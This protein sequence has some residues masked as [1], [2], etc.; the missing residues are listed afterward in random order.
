MR[1]SWQQTRAAL[2][3]DWRAGASEIRDLLRSRDLHLALWL[4][5]PALI[6]GAALR[7]HF[8]LE[9]PYGFFLSDTRDFIDAARNFLK[10]PLGVFGGDS[11]T[12]LAPVLYSVPVALGAP[13][14]RVVPWGQHAIGLAM[15]VLA[16]LLCAAWLRRW[17]LWIVPVTLL[18]AAHPTVLWYEH[19]AL[20][21]SMFVALAVATAAAVALFLRWPSSA[22][23]SVLMA[24]VFLAAG[25]RQEGF[26][27]ALA[28]AVAAT[29]AFR[30]DAR[31]MAA[32][33]LACAAFIALTTRASRTTQGGQMLLTSLIHLAPD[34]LFLTPDYSARAVALRERFGP[35]WPMYPA[36]H[37]KSRDIIVDDMA[38]FLRD[39][40]GL[41]E[42]DQRLTNNA[43]CKWVALEIAVR[44]WWALPRI[45]YNKWRATHLEPPS[46]P[47]GGEWPAQ[48]ALKK[49]FGEED[50]K[51]RKYLRRLFGR[52]Y[53]AA[54]AFER[55]LREVYYR[56]GRQVLLRAWQ[57]WF[58]PRSLWPH[59]PANVPLEGPGE[60]KQQMPRLPWLYP[61]G[62][63]GLLCAALAAD[64]PRRASILTWL[65]MLLVVAFV[66]GL[67][68]SLR[69]RYRLTFEP[70]WYIG[71]AGLC[72]AGLALALAAW[73]N[74]RA[75]GRARGQGG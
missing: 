65:S 2:A 13:L 40:R 8:C 48:Y 54:D 32:Y 12:F 69:S 63:A 35:Q 15:I 68:G 18:A 11:R 33:L 70:Y 22:T 53:D 59:D 21:E 37:N 39:G 6:L 52:S 66:V 19:M 60:I 51:E 72:D 25:A 31:R 64:R 14:L 47:F 71:L 30:R 50:S 55:D 56:D 9:A 45:A 43:A 49:S 34:R 4:C 42:T 58:I 5:V 41:S 16:G 36:K 28:P 23:F 67:V 3:A 73:R 17:R 1:I 57:E 62:L 74:L 10:G 29:V 20:P 26:L 44:R 38:S 75:G 7:A 61:L 27:F 46:P 24:S